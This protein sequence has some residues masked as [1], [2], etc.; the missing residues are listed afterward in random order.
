M[1]NKPGLTIEGDYSV[2]GTNPEGHK[3]RGKVTIRK[4]G[5]YYMLMWKIG[6]DSYQGKGLISGKMLTV[7]W[8]R[9]SGYL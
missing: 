9:L 5:K 2:L 6:K 1:N 3:Y 4:Q 8:G 7:N